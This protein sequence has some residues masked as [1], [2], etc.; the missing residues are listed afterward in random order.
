MEG[1]FVALCGKAG[2][3]MLHKY[4]PNALIMLSSRSLVLEG[5]CLQ[6]NQGVCI[7]LI[8]QKLC[9]AKYRAIQS[10]P[11]EVY[12]QACVS[13]VSK[14]VLPVSDFIY[15]FPFCV[16]ICPLWGHPWISG[17]QRKDKG[18][19]SIL[20]NIAD[21]ES[22]MG[23]N[24]SEAVFQAMKYCQENLP[25]APSRDLFGCI[26]SRS[27]PFD[28]RTAK[29]IFSQIVEAVQDVR[30][31]NF[32]HN[33]IKDE[34]ILIDNHFNIKL[35]DFG[36]ADFITNSQRFCGTL[37]FAS[38]ELF[39]PGKKRDP[40]SLEIWTLGSV[41]YLML[42]G[43]YYAKDIETI[44]HNKQLVEYLQTN[45]AFSRFPND[46]QIILKG[47]LAY[48]S[49]NRISLDSLAFELGISKNILHPQLWL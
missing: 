9:Q 48:S 1:Y 33:D 24:Q 26:D 40:K 11:M 36:A 31:C 16:V 2:V 35:I 44:S 7:K 18:E 27:G 39:I 14:Y 6:T 23:R 41:L 43:D 38:P 5:Q 12:S 32:L 19:C 28:S 22:C 30:R 8:P 20:P 10:F 21:I 45:D 29:S 15:G 47:C 17:S 13:N 25:L 42:T 3:D 34:N 37:A 46:I 49:T 4:K